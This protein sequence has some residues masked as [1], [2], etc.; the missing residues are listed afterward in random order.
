[1][2]DPSSTHT[3]I[4]FNGCMRLD[5]AINSSR[6]LVA[7]GRDN[8][9]QLVRFWEIATQYQLFHA[10]ATVGVAALPEE[11]AVP[12]GVGFLAGEMQ[13]HNVVVLCQP[14]HTHRYYQYHGADVDICLLQIFFCDDPYPCSLS[15]SLTIAFGRRASLSLTDVVSHYLP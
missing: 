7:Q 9:D 11:S 6:V 2:E 5:A 13:C 4:Y 12:A 14:M 8:A 3:N 1:M 15:T 10:A